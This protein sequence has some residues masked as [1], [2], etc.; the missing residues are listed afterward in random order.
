M[1]SASHTLALD[2]MKATPRD[3]VSLVTGADPSTLRRSPGRGQWSAAAVV[4]HL[5]DAELVYSVRLRMMIAEPD[6]LLPAFDEKAWS[7]RFTDLEEDPKEALARWRTLRDA[8]VRLLESLVDAEWT[9]SGMH[10]ERGQMNV[11]DV[12]KLL[13]DH[14]RTHLDQIR[15]ALA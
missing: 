2:R 13:A 9:R 12:V 5:A 8:N 11:G 7:D 10:E 6:P 14:D 4:A 3:L 1:P 15:A